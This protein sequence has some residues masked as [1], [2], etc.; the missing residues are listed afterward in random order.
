MNTQLKQEPLSKG[1]FRCDIVGSFLRPE[2][3][4]QA[5]SDFSKVKITRDDLTQIEDQAIKNLVEQEK[6][7]GLSA[8]TDGEFRRR[9]WHLDF[10]AALGGIQEIGAQQW[11]VEFKGTQPKAATVKITDKV[12]FG[13]HP[14]LEH[15]KYLQSV[16][17]DTLCKMTIPSPSMLHL[18]SC[19]REQNYQPIDLYK[20]EENLYR[21]IAMAYQDAIRA[22]YD[23]GCRY[24]QLDDTSWGEFCDLE[25]RKAYADRGFDLDAIASQYVSMINLALEAKPSDMVITMHICRGNFRSTWFS[26]GGYTPIAQ[27]LF[28]HCNV[29]GFFLEYDSDRAGDFEPLQYI[30]DQKVVLGLVTSKTPELEDEQSIINRIYEAARYVKLD[31]LCLSPQCGFSSTEE[32]N[33]LTQEEQWK[34]LKMIKKIS[35]RV[36]R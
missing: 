7:I 10:I 34:K 24:L 15:F 4:K 25:K 19:V 27:I 31:Q 8:V 30:R 26:S 18:I 28:G 16:A 23:I 6:A 21:D 9:Y 11:S 2:K 35:D 17:G 12:T 14:F 20:D 22:F 5:R 29:D 1:P 33:M 3:L 13:P 36:W 32:G